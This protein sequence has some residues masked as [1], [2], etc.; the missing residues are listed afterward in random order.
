MKKAIFRK[1]VWMILL[2]L[3]VSSTV[4]SLVISKR[5]LKST[6]QEMVNTL[7]MMDYA[8]DYEGDLEQQIADLCAID[9]LWW[10]N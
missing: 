3:V 7:H 6:E 5:N 2:A 4:L 8:L 9:G 10:Q 1:F